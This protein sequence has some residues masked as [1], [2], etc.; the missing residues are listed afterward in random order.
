MRRWME[1]TKMV[2][3]KIRSKELSRKSAEGEKSEREEVV[4]GSNVIWERVTWG[5]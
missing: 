4:A 3:V 1:G 5:T 2:M